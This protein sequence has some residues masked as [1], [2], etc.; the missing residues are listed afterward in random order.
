MTTTPRAH[1]AM[2]SIAAHGHVNPSLEVIRELVARGHRVSYA[3]PASFAEKVA[4]TGAEPVIYT[5]AAAHRRRPGGLGQRTDRPRRA[6]PRR[7]RSRPCRSSPRPTT[8]DEPDLVLHDITS[9]PAR[10][11]AHRWGVPAVQLSPEPRR[12]GGVRGGGRRARDRRAEADRA[13]P[14]LLRALRRPGSTE[15]GLGDLSR[16]DFVARPRRGLVLIPEALQPNADRVDETGSPSSA[17]ARATGPT[18]GS[19]SGP[20]VPRRCCWS[21][22]ARPSPSSP[23]STASAS[24]PSATCRAGTWCSRSAAQVDP[25]ELGRRTGQRRGA[26]LGAAVVGAEA[27]RRLHHARRRGRQP[28]GA[29]H[30]APRWSPYRRPSTSSATRTCSRPSASPGTCRRRRRTPRP[31]APPSSPWSTIPRSPRGSP[32]SSE[33]MAE[34][35]GA[36]RAADLIEAELPP[37]EERSGRT[38]RRPRA[39]F[40]PAGRSGGVRTVR[41]TGTPHSAHAPSAVMLRSCALDRDEFTRPKRT[42]ASVFESGPDGLPGIG[43]MCAGFL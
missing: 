37:A 26:L 13:R 43:V 5:S 8:G 20:P 21:R 34:E 14:G 16:D 17:P 4:E 11:L 7:T 30:R 10:V 33:R 9:Y 24:R 39:G 29:R 23:A 36:R 42:W 2:F 38:P 22:S 25:A 35:G 32:G 31:C 3:I 19:G 28:G 18:R 27:G 1:I 40:S 15:N 41:T 6:V 12:L